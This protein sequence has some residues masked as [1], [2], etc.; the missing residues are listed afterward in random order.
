MSSDT[1]CYLFF[2][3]SVFNVYGSARN[4]QLIKGGRD[5]YK[6]KVMIMLIWHLNKEKC[7]L[8]LL[9]F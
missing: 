8:I 3:M 9:L 1:H 5:Y 6:A 7:L 2:L 4:L